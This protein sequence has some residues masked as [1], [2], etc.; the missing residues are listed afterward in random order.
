ML[1]LK[2]RDLMFVGAGLGIGDTPHHQ[3]L[4]YQATARQRSI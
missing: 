3:A 4:F 1:A 2:E